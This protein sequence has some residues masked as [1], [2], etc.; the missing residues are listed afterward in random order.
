MPPRP[1]RNIIPA[2]RVLTAT[3]PNPYGY[4][5]PYGYNQYGNNQYGNNQYGYGVNSQAVIGQCASAV[6]MRLNGGYGGY[7]GGYGYNGYGNAGGRVLGISR[8]EQRE[9]GGLV[10]RGVAS[11]GRYGGYGYGQAQ[12]QP[13]L[14]W[15]CRTDFRGAIVDINVNAA[16]RTR[17]GYYN[18]NDYTPWNNDYSQYGYQRY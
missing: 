8:I 17:G 3:A 9:N 7:G 1:R 12:A 2:T 13:D 6:Q 18:N 16:Q 15:S 14:V 5:Q 10:V 4:G 11:S